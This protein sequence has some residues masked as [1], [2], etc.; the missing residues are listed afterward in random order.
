MRETCYKFVYKKQENLSIAI[1]VTTV[2]RL[3]YTGI[4]NES[5]VIINLC[6]TNLHLD[7]IEIQKHMFLYKNKGTF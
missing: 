5:K 7:V 6:I 4:C 2:N 3:V 1:A